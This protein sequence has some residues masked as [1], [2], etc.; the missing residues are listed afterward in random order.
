MHIHTP[1]L[2]YMHPC[3]CNGF[4]AGHAAAHKLRVIHHKYTA[5]IA[6]HTRAVERHARKLVRLHS[7]HTQINL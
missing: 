7:V 6:A 5:Q 2:I 1:F 4:R 3:T